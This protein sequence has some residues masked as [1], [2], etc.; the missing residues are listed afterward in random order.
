MSLQGLENVKIER[1]PGYGE[2]LICL[3]GW[4]SSVGGP[5]WDIGTFVFQKLIK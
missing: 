3:L 2:H 5:R 1:W 4:N